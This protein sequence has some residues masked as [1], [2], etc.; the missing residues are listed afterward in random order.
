MKQP[1]KKVLVMLT[2]IF[3]AMLRLSYWQKQ[4]K[5]AEVFL[6]PKPGKDPKELSPYRPINLL[7]TA[8][9]IFE[10][11]LLRRLNTDLKPDDWMPPHQFGFRNN[12]PQ[13]NKH[14]DS[15]IPYIKY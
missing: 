7:F 14:T 9:K 1:P 4:L 8:N 15:F 3:N 2:Y 13:Y 11:L 5:T 12:I 6:I 10:K